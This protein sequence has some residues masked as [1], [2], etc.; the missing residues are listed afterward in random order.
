[1]TDKQIIID[2]VDVAD[3]GH[4]NAC[5]KK[6]K[7]VIL[8]DD[9]CEINPYCEGFNCYYKQ[10]KRK[11]QDCAELKK[12]VDRLLQ[13]L[14]KAQSEIVQKNIDETNILLIKENMDLQQQL[15]QLKAENDELKKA[16]ARTIWRVNAFP[17]RGNHQTIFPTSGKR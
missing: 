16:Y 14:I 7:C 6:M 9:I 13:T 11:E 12:H 5:D 1:M 10:L 15:D 2:G 3:C 4:I 17:T 8:Q